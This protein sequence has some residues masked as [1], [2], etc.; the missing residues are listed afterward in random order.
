MYTITSPGTNPGMLLQI[1]AAPGSSGLELV[2]IMDLRRAGYPTG[3]PWLSQ[4]GMLFEF[5][6]DN[7]TPRQSDTSLVVDSSSQA[8]DG[9]VRV[10]AHAAA[11]PVAFTISLAPHP[12]EA[13]V[14]VN[15]L[16]W[17]TDPAKEHFL[18]LVLPK[19]RGLVGPPGAALMGCVPR[20][21]GSVAPLR[22]SPIV[23]MKFEIDKGLPTA[24][25]T[26]EVASVYDRDG[27]GVFFADTDGDLNRGVAPLQFNLS[28]GEVV[29]FW[30]AHIPPG[31][32]VRTP[33]LGIGVHPS[34][35][36]R[37]AVDFYL[38]ANA[39][40]LQSFPD[41]P[42]WFREAGA[43]YTFAGG[44]AGSIYLE[45]GPPSQLGD[46]A[47]FS[48]WERG[49]GK[50]RDGLAAPAGPFD[51]RN[52]PVQISPS[53]FT[54][55]GAPLLAI[56][57]NDVQVDVIAVG[58]DGAL[59]ATWESGGGAWRDGR[60]GRMPARISPPG[61]AQPG[62][63]LS[64]AKQNDRQLDVFWAGND[65]A[66]WVTW[67]AGDSAWRDGLDGRDPRP[68]TPKGFAV[69][70]SA[71][72]AAKQNSAQLDVFWVR[73]DGAVWVTWE[74]GDS[75]WR[76]GSNNGYPVRV[77]PSGLA[78]PGAPL[79]AILQNEH[80]LDV[81]V[82]GVDR[83][84]WLTW[85]ADDG[86]W[87]E[88]D[89]GRGPARV[90]PP[91]LFPPGAHVAAARQND[92][93]LVVFAIGNDGA[94]WASWEVD[95]GPWR[96]GAAGRAPARVTPAGLAPPGAPLVA[97][98]QNP[99][100]LNVFF[101]DHDGAIRVTFERNDSPWTDGMDGRPEPFAVT[102]KGFALPGAGVAAILRPDGQMEAYTV[103]PGRITSFRELYKL[104]E[105]ATDLGTNVVYLW[106]YWEGADQGGYPPYWNKGDYIPR[107]DLGGAQ[108][109]IDGIAE[110]HRQK[111]RIIA[112]VEPFIIFIFSQNAPRAADWAGLNADN[113]PY[114]TYPDN[115]PM[116]A[117]YSNWQD[118]VVAVA[119]R[120]V[121]VY[122]FDGVFLDS[123]TWQ[124]NLS[125][126]A[127]AEGRLYRPL[128]WSQ[129]VLEL[130]RRVR[131]AVRAINPEAVVLGET[132]AGP[133]ALVWDGGLAADFYRDDGNKENSWNQFRDMNGGRLAA[134]PARYGLPSMNYFSN[135]LNLNE[136]HQVFA[137]GYNLALCNNW[138][139]NFMHDN[140]SH[141]QALVQARRDYK[142][143]LVY[144]RQEYPPRAGAP[145]AVVAYFYRGSKTQVITVVNTDEKSSPTIQLDLAETERDSLWGDVLNSG[146]PML[147]ANGT[148]LAGITLGPAGDPART[149]I[150]VLA[151][152]LEVPPIAVIQALGSMG[153]DFSVPE[154]D[155]RDWLADPLSTPYPAISQALLLLGGRLK[156]PVFLDAIVWNYEHTPGV[157]S[158]RT[159]ADVKLDVL[160][161]AVLEGSNVRY[162]TNVSDFEQLLRP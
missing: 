147:K 57:Q 92:R 76:D 118:Y 75:A 154:A 150:R 82:V 135:G 117:P 102:P 133:I 33:T 127:K 86:P 137:A 96:D 104:L 51:P 31:G 144:G 39:S 38:R 87:R 53:G 134:A 77:S 125:M 122:G 63:P 73:E 156:A 48:T 41:T 6:V 121:C 97:A 74:A 120:L 78:P 119:K 145:D 146:L 106:D 40:R 4:P 157:A 83:A 61:V 12:T 141:I 20:E 101:V 115:Y 93:Q 99:S 108:A 46:G 81:F 25:N 14:L 50:W 3:Y 49:D 151:R 18:R 16:V 58:S 72:A 100:Q 126:K 91:G 11:D 143:A 103:A 153:V 17:N 109:L 43:I 29:A 59:W 162:G 142:D 66:I 79:A 47:V 62:A 116:V 131:E 65:G 28:A 90:T 69:P 2:G 128:E 30:I 149:D 84:I 5:A 111:G 15:L 89:E 19:I 32:Q 158:P 94:V 129:G 107:G 45:Q 34:G 88:G 124:M 44:G 52:L 68:I 42:A 155:L 67:E 27:G 161:A 152:T 71:T 24:M 26:M 13:A 113:T 140:A 36:W 21:L 23:G 138:P 132:T 80:Q 148:Q 10:E 70:G 159:V 123:W 60:A 160:K 95:D 136:L 8:A 130:A 114:V 139:G 85:E 37:Q 64:A 22:D 112:Y 55:A 56:A 105:E 1:D 9:S 7:G 110:V 35:D 54:P 98:K